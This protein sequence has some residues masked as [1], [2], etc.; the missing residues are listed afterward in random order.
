MGTLKKL[1]LG[2]LAIIGGLLAFFKFNSNKTDKVLKTNAKELGKVEAIDDYIN[3]RIDSIKNEKKYI[4]NIEK[5]KKGVNSE[6]N[7]NDNVDYIN[8]KY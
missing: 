3:D 5:R 7:T 6:D 2:L 1:G 4:E 8:S